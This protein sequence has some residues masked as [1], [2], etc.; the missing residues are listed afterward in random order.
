MKK[1]FAIQCFENSLGCGFITDSYQYSSFNINSSMLFE[2]EKSAV[3]EVSNIL[4]G[5][6]GYTYNIL[7]VL[8]VYLADAQWQTMKIKK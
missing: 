4:N 6:G 3:E 5:K 7:A 8:P 2:D 1:Y